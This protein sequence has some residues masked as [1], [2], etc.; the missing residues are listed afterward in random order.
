LVPEAVLRSGR[1]ESSDHAPVR[2]R[3]VASVTGTTPQGDE[4]LTVHFVDVGQA[5]EFWIHTADDGIPGNGRFEGA[6][7]RH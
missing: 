1:S 4:W 7:H 5:T 2:D 3:S 6:Q